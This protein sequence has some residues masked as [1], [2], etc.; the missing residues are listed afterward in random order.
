MIGFRSADWLV[1]RLPLGASRGLARVMAWLAFGIG[2]PARRNLEANLERLHPAASRRHIRRL[3]RAAFANFA[4]SFVDLLR[5]SRLAP[6]RVAR[7]VEVHGGQHLEAARRSGR[8]VIVL[9]AHVGNWEWGA[10]FLSALG[11]RVRVAAREQR[12]A[13]LERWFARSRGRHGIARLAGAPLW[14]SAARAL[15]RREWVALMGDRDGARGSGSMCAWSAALARRTGALI[16]P[17]VI[18]RRPEGG[19]AACFEPPMTP[20]ECV[21]TYREVVRSVLER[22]PGQ[23]LGFEAMPE[24]LA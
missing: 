12:G 6:E 9:S 18:V 11:E 23:W 3:A 19:Y 22:H 4:L 1:Q 7:E 5:L 21:D 17:A 10:A 2:V 14:L 20:R 24:G 16:L 15:R 13:S 8:G